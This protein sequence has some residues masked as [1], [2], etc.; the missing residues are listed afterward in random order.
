[1]NT[2]TPKPAPQQGQIHTLAPVIQ[3]WAELCKQQAER[4]PSAALRWYLE[5]RADAHQMDAI[6][7]REALSPS[8]AQAP[9]KKG[10]AFALAYE[11]FL[12]MLTAV[13][14]TDPATLP[15]PP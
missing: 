13:I 1:M 9:P 4:E 6:R 12:N 10:I 2:L 5:G 11:A 7:I 8:L 3:R 15:E 14:Q